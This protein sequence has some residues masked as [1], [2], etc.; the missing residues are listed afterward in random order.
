M[1]QDIKKGDKDSVTA[2]RELAL[3]YAELADTKDKTVADSKAK[4][5][6][7]Y[8]VGKEGELVESTVKRPP[9]EGEASN[10]QLDNMTDL[11]MSDKI[12]KLSEKDTVKLARSYQGIIGEYIKDNFKTGERTWKSGKEDPTVVYDR[13]SKLYPDNKAIKSAASAWSAGSPLGK[14][15]REY[16]QKLSGAKSL[17]DNVEDYHDLIDNMD[18]KANNWYGSLYTKAK[19]AVQPF[20]DSVALEE[21]TTKS[22]MEGTAK[23][24]FEKVTGIK[25][26]PNSK[27]DI[28]VQNTEMFT[29]SYGLAREIMKVGYDEQGKALSDKDMDAAMK[30]IAPGF[31]STATKATMKTAIDTAMRSLSNKQFRRYEG[32]FNENDKS[33]FEMKTQFLK[34]F[35]KKQARYMAKLHGKDWTDALPTSY[36]DS[37]TA[38]TPTPTTIEQVSH[39]LPAVHKEVA[40]LIALHGEGSDGVALGM[41]KYLQ[42]KGLSESQITAVFKYLATPTAQK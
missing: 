38:G 27:S 8:S 39:H 36:R 11:I 26:N 12:D 15:K 16:A 4:Q 25:L 30:M 29:M 37:T 1:W 31:G 19:G 18:P 14:Q 13:L 3:K 10:A 24:T 23:S 17:L 5:I 35:D 9:T 20:F 6:T 7:V 22:S 32:L 2:K 34:T 42:G 21:G 33:S 28:D 40:R 41:Q